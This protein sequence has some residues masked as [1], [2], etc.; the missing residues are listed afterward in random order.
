[1]GELVDRLNAMDSR[2]RAPGN[3]V[4]FAL[5]GGGLIVA[6]FG[7]CRLR[8]DGFTANGFTA[9]NDRRHH[10]TSGCAGRGHGWHRPP[11]HAARRWRWW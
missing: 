6:G 2:P 3:L 1:M 9:L 10:Q 7:L 5:N 8:R 11:G 4:P